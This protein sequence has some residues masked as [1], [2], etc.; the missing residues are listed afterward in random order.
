MD[1]ETMRAV[2]SALRISNA[3]RDFIASEVAGNNTK[4]VSNGDTKLEKNEIVYSAVFAEL[5]GQVPF[6]HVKL[7]ISFTTR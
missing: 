3:L 5:P 6:K 1:T 4:I 2:V 7:S